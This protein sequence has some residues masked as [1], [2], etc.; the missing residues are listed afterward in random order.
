MPQKP[1]AIGL[2]LCEQ[3]IVE[4]K[5]RNVTPVNCFTRRNSCSAESPH[6]PKGEPNTT[7]SI[8]DSPQQGE[9]AGFDSRNTEVVISDGPG[10]TT[11][12]P[13]SPELLRLA[14]IER[15]KLARFQELSSPPSSSAPPSDESGAEKMGG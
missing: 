8:A 9:P 3:V 10:D 7:T 13:P 6:Y 2:F 1:A 4:E 5:T 14:L 11:V 12:R 15:E